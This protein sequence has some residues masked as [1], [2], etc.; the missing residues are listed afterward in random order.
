MY[1]ENYNIKSKTLVNASSHKML[2][3]FKATDHQNS[4]VLILQLQLDRRTVLQPVNKKLTFKSILG[5]I[6]HLQ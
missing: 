4:Y 5:H 1:V 2:I 3:S 6:A